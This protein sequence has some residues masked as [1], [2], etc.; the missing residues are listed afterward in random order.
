MLKPVYA[1][2]EA[3]GRQVLVAAVPAVPVAMVAAVV[4]QLNLVEAAVRRVEQLHL[5]GPRAAWLLVLVHPEVAVDLPAA[6]VECARRVARLD[7]QAQL[8]R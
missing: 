8:D 7:Q 4:R 1:A 5:V 2:V 6:A 3:T